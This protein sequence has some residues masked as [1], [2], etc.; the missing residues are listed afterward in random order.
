[1]IRPLLSTFLALVVLGLWLVVFERVSALVHLVKL[2]DLR[3][4]A[5]RAMFAARAAALFCYFVY[6]VGTLL[7]LGRV[8]GYWH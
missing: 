2:V 3:V 4:P 7:A 1:M 8:W 5:H 6:A